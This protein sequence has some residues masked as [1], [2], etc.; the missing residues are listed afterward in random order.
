MRARAENHFDARVR[1]QSEIDQRGREIS[2]LR[3]EI[4]DATEPR[5]AP[6]PH[7]CM[8]TDHGPQ[9]KAG[10][11]DAWCRRH[12][13]QQ[14]LGAIGKYGSLPVIE[15]YIRSLKNE[16]T[17]QRGRCVDCRPRQRNRD[18]GSRVGAD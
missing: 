12:G 10:A 7:W 4:R 2:L 1:L 13:I 5:L 15:R 14:R 9:F 18:G 3:E 8:I 17:R 16:C 6:R 11:F